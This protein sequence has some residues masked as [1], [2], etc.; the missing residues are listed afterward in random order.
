MGTILGIIIGF[1]VVCIVLYWVL[2]GLLFAFIKMNDA[3]E[4]TQKKRKDEKQTKKEMAKHEKERRQSEIKYNHMIEDASKYVDRFLKSDFLRDVLKNIKT[5][6]IIASVSVGA[7]GLTVYDADIVEERYYKDDKVSGRDRYFMFNHNPIYQ[8]N[9]YSYP[10][11]SISYEKLGYSPIDANS[12][13][14]RTLRGDGMMEWSEEGFKKIIAF[15]M[16]L[17]ISLHQDF[18]MSVYEP[19]DDYEHIY[20]GSVCLYEKRFIRENKGEPNL[21]TPI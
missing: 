4:S 20:N 16:A 17:Q 11:Q 3:W 13:K 10:S 2:R 15:A 19:Y 18:E 8:E 7:K 21:K 6:G 1:F 9:H 12:S 5:D 14:V